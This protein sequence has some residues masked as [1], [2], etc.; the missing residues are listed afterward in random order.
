M[1]A[2]PVRRQQIC[3]RRPRLY[4]GQLCRSHHLAQLRATRR[5]GRVRG[6]QLRESGKR[7]AE[8]G[9]RRSEHLLPARPRRIHRLPIIVRGR[10]RTGG[11]RHR[12]GDLRRSDRAELRL[13]AFIPDPIRIVADRR[14]SRDA[15]H[16][17]TLDL[18]R[19]HFH[20]RGRRVDRAIRIHPRHQGL[21]GGSGQCG[22]RTEQIALILVAAYQPEC[23]RRLL[24]P[25]QSGQ[26]IVNT[27]QRMPLG[28]VP[29][30][31]P[32]RIR[33]SVEHRLPVGVPIERIRI[34]D[35]RPRRHPLVGPR[36][37]LQLPQRDIHRQQRVLPGLRQT[38]TVG[39]HLRLDPGQRGQTHQQQNQKR[40]E[41]NGYNQSKSS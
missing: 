40:Q 30:T 4:K 39:R 17:R 24:A 15:R 28:T 22:R 37:L 2:E 23:R 3:G 34:K 41:R 38:L 14:R 26:A 8:G 25:A 19:R 29:H 31:R 33:H 20:P 1:D 27:R 16:Q 7:R 6:E 32:I 9:T 36:G 21:F 13:H 5:T 11:G 12:V 10:H 18:H 35:L